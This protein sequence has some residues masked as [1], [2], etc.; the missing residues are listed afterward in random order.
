M[1]L[2][3]VEHRDNQPPEPECRAP[4]PLLPKRLKHLRGSTHN[5]AA[6]PRGPTAMYTMTIQIAAGAISG[7]HSLLQAL[8]CWWRERRTTAELHSL[9]DA[10]LKD[11]G[12]SRRQIPSI[13]RRYATEFGSM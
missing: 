9:N 12:I 6:K 4:G 3:V 11:I 10:A 1:S 5:S 8:R 7:A 13:A 2:R